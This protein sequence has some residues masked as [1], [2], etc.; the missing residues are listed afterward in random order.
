MIDVD[1]LL[2]A[3]IVVDQD[4]ISDFLEVL[5]RGGG[6][7]IGSTT[8]QPFLPPDAARRRPTLKKRRPL[9]KGWKLYLVTLT[10]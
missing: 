10:A 7:F 6:R 2:A 9:L 4:K 5:G 1:D 3:L 8:H